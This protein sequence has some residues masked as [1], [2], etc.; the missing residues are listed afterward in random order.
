VKSKNTEKKTIRKHVLLV[1]SLVPESID[2]YLLPLSEISKRGRWSLKRAHGHFLNTVIPDDAKYPAEE[3]DKALFFIN[4]A[5]IDDPSAEW[6]NDQY[7]EDQSKQ[8]GVS[9]QRYMRI[10]GRWREYK[11]DKSEINKLP[12]CRLISTGIIM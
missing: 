9:K 1:F 8:L 12:R 4:E 7:I 3:V 11:L 5:L 6:I 2:F 10:L